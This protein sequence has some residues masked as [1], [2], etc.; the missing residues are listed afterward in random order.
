MF[1]ETVPKF[2]KGCII[3]WFL[4]SWLGIVWPHE[5][6]GLN[7]TSSIISSKTNSYFKFVWLST[8]KTLLSVLQASKISHDIYS[9]TK[10]GL[11]SKLIPTWRQISISKTMY[12]LMKDNGNCHLA[13][14]QDLSKALLYFRNFN[15]NQ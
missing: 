13:F 2:R 5:S 15:W 8:L 14:Q 1:Q 6:T 12:F 4:N 11:I 3:Q 7:P 9:K 10:Q